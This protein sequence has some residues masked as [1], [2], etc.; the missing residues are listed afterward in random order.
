MTGFS[1]PVKRRHGF[2]QPLQ[3]GDPADDPDFSSFF[4]KARN[5]QQH[6]EI[7]PVHDD[8]AIPGGT[9]LIRHHS[10]LTPPEQRFLTAHP[11]QET[12]GHS[13]N[14]VAKTITV[15]QGQPTDF[16][17]FPACISGQCIASRPPPR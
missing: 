4:G 15:H 7:S 17:V 5:V 12:V 11:A 16:P 6:G 10:R 14:F 3:S 1:S 13:G 8:P 9:P 2:Q